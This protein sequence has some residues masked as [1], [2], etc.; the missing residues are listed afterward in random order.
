MK[1]KIS[2]GWGIIFVLLAGACFGQTTQFGMGLVLF[3]PSGLTAKVWLHKAGA[4]D[5]AIGWSGMEGHYLQIQADY[6]FFSPRIASDKNLQFSFYVGAGGKIIFQENDNAWFRI[7]LGID[8]VLKKTPLNFF[9]EIVPY[10]NFEKID[11]TGAIGFRYLFT[12]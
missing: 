11:V 12:K 7:P 6:L 10:F 5:G 9:F 8:V 3:D 4:I 1:K 2:I